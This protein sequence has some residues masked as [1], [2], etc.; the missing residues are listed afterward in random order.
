[1]AQLETI[2]SPLGVILHQTDESIPGSTSVAFNEVGVPST[3]SSLHDKDLPSANNQ[4]FSFDPTSLKARYKV[5]RDKRLAANP[6]GVDQYRSI[7]DGDPVFGH[8]IDDPYVERTKRSPVSEQLEALIVG[9]GY[10][11]QLVAVRL[12]EM[13]ITDIRIVE[14]GGDFGGTWYVDREI[15]F[16][17]MSVIY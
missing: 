7:K 2:S 16:F 9:G 12:M 11:G 15:S 8:Y 3:L 10:G 6:D 17:S 14:K 1:M 5:E 13:G 4:D